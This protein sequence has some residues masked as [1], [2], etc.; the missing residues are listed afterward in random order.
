M[1]FD[2]EPLLLRKR[3]A[4]REPPP[5]PNTGWHPPAYYPDL[6]CA[7]VIAVDTETKDP[8]LDEHGPGWARGPVGHIVGVSIAAIMQD[9]RRGKWYFPVRHEA[10]A[11]DNLDPA[12]TFA[13]LKATLET[14]AIPKVGAN[15]PYDMGW[16]REEGIELQGELIDVQTAE[17]L[18]F[19]DGEVN[20]EYLGAKY[21]GRGKNSDLLYQWCA[22]A[23][24]GAA[25]PKQRA[26]IYRC[27]PR[28]VGSYAE[29]DADI[30]LD[31]F[32][33]QARLLVADQI[34]DLFRLECSLLPLLVKMRFAGASVSIAETEIV[35]EEITQ[36]LKQLNAELKHKLGFE[37][38]V[39]SR[40]HLQK[41]FDSV[42][43]RYPKSSD[44]KGS[45]KK[46]WLSAQEHWLPKAIVGLREHNTIQNTFL[47]SYILN[48]SSGRYGNSLAKIHCTFNPLRG[49]ESG[50]RTGRFS[51]NDPNLQN[52]PVRTKL[53][54]RVRKAFVPDYGHHCWRKYDYSQIEYRFH[55][56]YASGPG[57]ED[58]RAR[59]HSDPTTDYHVLTQLL[60]KEQTGKLI[61]RKPIKNINFGLLYGMGQAKLARQLGLSP[62]AA[63]ELFG[64]Y[65]AG[66]PYTRVTMEACAAEAQRLGYITTILG[67]R[68]RFDTWEPINVNYDN[69]A[70]A[71]PYELAIR[72]YGHAIQRA[73]THKAINSRYQGSAADQMK[74]A[75]A[76]LNASGVFDYTGVPRLTVHDELDFSQIDDS[77]QM[78]EAFDFIQNRMENVIQL[79]IPVRAD[80]GTGENW[81]S[82]E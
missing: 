60:V 25:G 27:P 81:G 42:G 82:I 8:E 44:G 41:A 7:A 31:V 55:V 12:H 17:A 50:T 36:T 56:H 52:I 33:Q 28:L 70:R 51:C 5:V 64:A 23:F 13:W 38:E 2:D 45:F 77:P 20:L 24:D 34:Y 14:P 9:G 54:K 15:L 47:R 53:G 65:H 32:G 68:R 59:Y 75:M 69:R 18:L 19:E 26:N 43:I 76:D 3:V 48:G 74:M 40:G 49:D 11:W 39:G 29:D 73:H 22:S 72:E 16:L 6:R 80:C 61:E 46:E 57:A 71:L 1:F 21:A 62:E 4:L 67:R 35:D 78:R 58:V 66:N 79:R 63:K 37:C 30:P 10:E